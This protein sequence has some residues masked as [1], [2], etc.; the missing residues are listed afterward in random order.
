[1]FEQNRTLADGPEIFNAQAIPDGRGQDI[2]VP[3]VLEVGMETIACGITLS[4][5][6][7]SAS[8][9]RHICNTV[10]HLQEDVRDL[11]WM[12]RR[13]YSVVDRTLICHMAVVRFV[14]IFTI[15]ATLEV[16]LSTHTIGT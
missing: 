7:T 6:E 8:L 14:K 13:T 10:K 16:N 4:E 9:F 3:A 15:P 1:M 12:R 5:D 2:S 11:Y